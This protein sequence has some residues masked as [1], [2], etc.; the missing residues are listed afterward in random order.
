MQKI[1]TVK[2]RAAFQ[3]GDTVVQ[4]GVYDT[5]D[6]PI[7]KVLLKKLEEKNPFVRVLAYEPEPQPVKKE[8]AKEAP[9]QE[10]KEAIFKPSFDSKK[11]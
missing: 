11:K 7:P 10:V 3:D 4:M 2:T 6:G 1:K 5:K 8:E 9:K